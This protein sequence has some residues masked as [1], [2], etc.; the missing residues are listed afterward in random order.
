MAKSRKDVFPKKP[1][2]KFLGKEV[3]AGL[4]EESEA[5]NEE[6]EL[7]CKKHNDN[8]GFVP[9]EWEQFA[10]EQGIPLPKKGKK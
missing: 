9:T 1:L 3:A 5:T 8:L 2:Y 10:L 7:A 4:N 6:I